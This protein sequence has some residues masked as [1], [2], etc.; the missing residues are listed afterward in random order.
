MFHWNGLNEFIAVV[1]AESFTLAAR[2]IGISTAQVSRQIN[3]LEERLGTR[4]FYRTTRR[5]SVTDA[6]WSFYRQC[7]PLIDSLLDAERQ[8][9]SLQS[10]PRGKLTMTAPITFGEQ[11]IAPAVTDFCLKYPQLNVTLQLTNQKLDLV[12]EGID[13]AIRL[14]ELEDSSMM[15]K[16]LGSRILHVVASPEYIEQHGAPQTIAELDKH[17][18]LQGTHGYWRF[19]ER[20]KP[21]AVRI[22]GRLCCNS[23]HALVEAAMKGLGIVQLPDNY[24]THHLTGGKLVELLRPYRKGP[25]G[26]WALY[27]HNRHLS[28]KVRLML[29]H[30][31]KRLD[32][33]RLND[34][35]RPQTG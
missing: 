1:E 26:I 7:R 24:V 32:E 8:L 27:P 34:T 25:E 18:C 28:N 6:G 33:F 16:R 10:S 13:L 30:L 31:E 17:N 5:V 3:A 11:H 29:E 20:D 35:Q 14:G 9:T 21:Q 23:G 22:T 12:D 15:A 4:L 2:R 19:S